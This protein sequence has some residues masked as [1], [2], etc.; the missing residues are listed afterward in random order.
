[1]ARPQTGV[2]QPPQKYGLSATYQIKDVPMHAMSIAHLGAMVPGLAQEIGGAKSSDRVDY[3]VGFGSL[4]GSFIWQGNQPRGFN[5]L[6]TLQKEEVFHSST[7]GDLWIFLSSQSADVNHK[8]EECVQNYLSKLVIKKELVE[9]T[10]ADTPYTLESRDRI[11]ID[12]SDPEFNQSC[13]VWV[14]GMENMERAENPSMGIVASGKER[15]PLSATAARSYGMYYEL[16]GENCFLEFSFAATPELFKKIIQDQGIPPKQ[17]F[18]PVSKG[19]F[20][21]PSVEVLVSSRM[22]TLRIGSLSPTAKWKEC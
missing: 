7:D 22:G 11:L 6:H 4:L 17:N 16:Q 18:Q 2:A 10:M 21:L 12:S 14:H 19:F 15:S 1:M 8:L 9:G 3:L 20:F 5:R 13:F